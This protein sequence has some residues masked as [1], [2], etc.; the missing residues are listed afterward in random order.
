M[1]V[2]TY[3]E[4]IFMATLYHSQVWGAHTSCA[5]CC[6]Y[7][8]LY[9][10]LHYIETCLDLHI[11]SAFQILLFQILFNNLKTHWNQSWNLLAFNL[12]WFLAV[13]ITCKEAFSNWFKQLNKIRHILHVYFTNNKK[14]SGREKVKLES[15]FKW[16]YVNLLIHSRNLTV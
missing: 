8:W 2:N 15:N 5:F 1:E 10:V 16:R 9:L 14:V 12:V 7:V 6:Y 3:I 4:E 11:I 13:C